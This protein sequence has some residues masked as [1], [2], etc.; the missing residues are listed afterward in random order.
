MAIDS[1]NNLMKKKIN[2]NVKEISDSFTQTLKH[3]TDSGLDVEDIKS[4]FTFLKAIP[5]VMA[6][7]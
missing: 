5:L 3:L 7:I 4:K 2:I 1:L 6:S